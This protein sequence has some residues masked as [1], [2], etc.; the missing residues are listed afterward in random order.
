MSEVWEITDLAGKKYG[1]W[2]ESPICPAKQN[3]VAAYR[4][5]QTTGFQVFLTHNGH[6]QKEED[7]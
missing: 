7:L 2:H 4:T 5:L 6:F 1:T 3:A